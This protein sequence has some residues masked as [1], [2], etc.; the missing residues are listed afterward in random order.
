MLATMVPELEALI[1]ADE[2]AAKNA[3]APR[4]RVR[5]GLYT[6]EAADPDSP[7]APPVPGAVPGA[8]PKLRRRAPVNE[9]PVP[10]SGR[11]AAASP[12]AAPL[13][14]HDKIPAKRR[15]QT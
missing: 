12:K 15:R 3:P 14:P 9:P 1:A 5:I 2:A 7:A 8:A 11:P 6:Y 4:R 10:R 13:K